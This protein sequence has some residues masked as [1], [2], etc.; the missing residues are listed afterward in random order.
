MMISPTRGAAVLLLVAVSLTGCSADRPAS[1]PHHRHHAAASPHPFA[2]TQL[3]IDEASHRYNTDRR[4]IN[5]VDIE[6]FQRSYE[7]RGNTLRDEGF[8]CTF[9]EKG[10]FLHLSMR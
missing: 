2:M 10:A 9:D 5:V 4:G 8:T 3:C 1:D 6:S 7:L